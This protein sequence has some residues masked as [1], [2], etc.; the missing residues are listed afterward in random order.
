M[1]NRFRFDIPDLRFYG[2]P[3]QNTV[4]ASPDRKHEESGRPVFAISSS[5][6]QFQIYHEVVHVN[7]RNRSTGEEDPLGLLPVPWQ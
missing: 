5:P 3:F 7:P 2:V 1:A 6:L 4:S